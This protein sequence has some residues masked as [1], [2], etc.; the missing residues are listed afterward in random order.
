[1]NIALIT[2]GLD[3]DYQIA[4]WKALAR[5]SE[6]R[7]ISLVA[8]PALAVFETTLQTVKTEFLK[9]RLQLGRFHGII[10]VTSSL[11]PYVS[12]DE[13]DDIIKAVP[14]IPVLSLGQPLKDFHNII[15]DNKQGMKGLAEHLLKKHHPRK[16]FLKLS[17]RTKKNMN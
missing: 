15:F 9:K 8:F 2:A 6:D 11:I 14:G 17:K 1:M 12:F 16:L 13:M 10:F 5:A 4:L 7:N 3:E